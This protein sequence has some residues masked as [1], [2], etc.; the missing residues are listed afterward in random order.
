MSEHEDNS[1]K[2]AKYNIG[3]GRPPKEGRFRPGQSGNPKGRP[4]K[5][6]E[7]QQKNL[8]AV[9]AGALEEEVAVPDGTK[10]I[11]I[12]RKQLMVRSLVEKSAKGSKRSFRKLL[13]LREAVEKSP[14]EQIVIRGTEILAMAWGRPVKRIDKP[15]WYVNGKDIPVDSEE[16]PKVVPSFRELMEIELDRE[17]WV[18]GPGP[19]RR[20]TMRAII[21]TQFTNAAAAGDEGAIELLLRFGVHQ[22]QDAN[23]PKFRH[24]V[25]PCTEEDYWQYE[26]RKDWDRNYKSAGEPLIESQEQYLSYFPPR[27]KAPEK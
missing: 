17:V 6:K 20:M 22:Y 1:Q 10:E 2:E 21:A 13:S 15:M 3:Y 16:A 9:F 25:Y 12:T 24:M 27:E 11:R 8:A 23:R 19:R 18:N 26:H 7:T 14:D 5:Q 4:K